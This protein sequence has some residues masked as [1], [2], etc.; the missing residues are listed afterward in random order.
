MLWRSRPCPQVQPLS[1][2]GILDRQKGR[3]SCLRHDTWDRGEEAYRGRPRGKQAESFSLSPRSEFSRV[4]RTYDAL[5]ILNPPFNTP[6]LGGF[7]IK[8]KHKRFPKENSHASDLSFLDKHRVPWQLF[9]RRTA[10]E[11]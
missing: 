11:V 8:N 5:C 7:L 1:V 4:L 6:H 2:S 10:M 9:V 3:E